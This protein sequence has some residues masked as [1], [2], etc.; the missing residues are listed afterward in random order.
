[1]RVDGG[2]GMRIAGALLAGWGESQGGRNG[3]VRR[4]EV[5]S[6]VHSRDKFR[7]PFVSFP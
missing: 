1:M 6:G 3:E 5:D 4:A 7:I 2:E